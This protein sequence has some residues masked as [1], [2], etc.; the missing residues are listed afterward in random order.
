[1]YKRNCEIK[2]GIEFPE[3]MQRVALCV[4]YKGT[5]F[6]GFQ[7]Q[8]SAADTVQAYL[9]K[10]LSKIANE[11]ITLVCA[12]RT[13][14]GVHATH[15]VIHFDTL[16]Q[17]NEK[18]WV[19]GTNT[20]LPDDI[21]IKW[22][23]PVSE[24]FHARFSALSRKYRYV[25]YCNPVK[26]GVCRD[27]VTWT[28][29]E[30]DFNAMEKA[31]QH[32][33]GEHDFSSFRAAQCQANNPVREIQSLRF[34]NSGRFVVMEVRANAF[35][36]HMVRN[37]AGT[38]IDIGRG[39]KSPDWTKKLLELKDRTQASPTAHPY[40]LYIVDVEYPKEFDL[41]DVPVGPDFICV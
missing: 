7:K 38:M 21:V 34:F 8:E 25:F 14:A 33:I 32:L 19:Q 4:E 37:I 11:P 36:H 39:A 10:A 13:D 18:A 26:P 41:P 30:L 3:G 1:M 28:R 15:Q 16:A 31:G 35:L 27:L 24:H 2:P 17:R 23:K 29:Y 12:G 22:C 40:G 5:R 9:E 20:N 6:H